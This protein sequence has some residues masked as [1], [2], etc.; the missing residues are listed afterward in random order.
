MPI[1]RSYILSFWFCLYSVRRQVGELLNVIRQADTKVDY[2]KQLNVR[3]S[4]LT[5][6]LPDPVKASEFICKFSNDLR[7]D[8]NLMRAMEII[9]SPNTDCKTC[10]ESVVSFKVMS[11]SCNFNILLF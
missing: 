2:N 1:I 3:I 9:V 8:K 10:A 11:A 4:S 5:K 6:F 7:E